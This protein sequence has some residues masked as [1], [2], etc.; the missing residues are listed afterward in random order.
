MKAKQLRERTDSEL[1]E[2]LIETKNK[3]FEA[4]IKNAT[5][6]LTNS[7]T[8]LKNRREIARINTI[9]NQRK[10]SSNSEGKE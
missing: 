6:Q 9:I 1:S 7:S 2:L 5:H 8:L 10:N 4:R 3:L